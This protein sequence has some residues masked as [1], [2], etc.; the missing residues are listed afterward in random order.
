MCSL[1]APFF[2]NIPLRTPRH[3]PRIKHIFRILFTSGAV[4]PYIIY[5]KIIFRRWKL[6]GNLFSPRIYGIITESTC[7][8]SLM[9]TG[10]I[11][12]LQQKQKLWVF[13][14]CFYDST[15]AFRLKIETDKKTI[16]IRKLSL[17]INNNA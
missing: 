17:Y 5:M 13:F 9:P 6:P 11:L 16:E 15:R 7:R 10:N 12:Q 4:R 14:F 2:L 8:I 3:S 1:R